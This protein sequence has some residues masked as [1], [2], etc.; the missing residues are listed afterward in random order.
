MLNVTNR[1]NEMIKTITCPNCKHR[2][3]VRLTNEKGTQYAGDSSLRNN[4]KGTQYAGDPSLRNNE[5]G[6]QYVSSN[7]RSAT[8]ETDYSNQRISKQEVH[9]GTLVCYG[10]RYPL[11]MGRNIVGR[12]AT[13]SH[14]TVQI[15]TSDMYISR[16][17]LLINAVAIGGGAIVTITNYKNT[18]R[19]FVN[20]ALLGKGETVNLTEGAQIKIGNTILLYT[21]Q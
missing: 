14:A 15:E 19:T 7:Q 20:G 3:T 11:K 9:A 16:D 5:K 13:T 12:K 6:T 17:H 8:D 2:F 21:K 1:K 18:N 10:K 4:E